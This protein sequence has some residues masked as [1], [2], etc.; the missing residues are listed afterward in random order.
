MSDCAK[1][2]AKFLADASGSLHGRSN[3]KRS[4]ILFPATQEL[5]GASDFRR[6]MCAVLLELHFQ[7]GQSDEGRK[8]LADLGFEPLFEQVEGPSG[9]GR[10]D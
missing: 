3:A 2:M 4:H 8:A 9:P 5:S 7:L 6:G 10:D 1:S